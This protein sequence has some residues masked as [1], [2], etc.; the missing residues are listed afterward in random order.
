MIIL[1]TFFLI[2]LLAYYLGYNFGKKFMK[3]LMLENSIEVDFNHEV[4]P[5][6]S[7]IYDIFISKGG[8]KHF[9][10]NSHSI[11]IPMLGLVLKTSFDWSNIEFIESEC[12]IDLVYDLY[13][14]PINIINAELSAS[15]K[16]ILYKIVKEIYINS[17][18]T[19]SV[20][21]LEETLE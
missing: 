14:K 3:E 6:V 2:F 16:K 21:F 17:Q 19:A 13:N 7:N 5:I 8:Y 11:E 4:H 15:D 20:L 9:K 10:E 1:F 18:E 12:D